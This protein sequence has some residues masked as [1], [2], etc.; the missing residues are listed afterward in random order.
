MDGRKR[1]TKGPG[2]TENVAIEEGQ[3]VS[4]PFELA[5]T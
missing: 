2:E 4:C 5:V 1:A 3:G